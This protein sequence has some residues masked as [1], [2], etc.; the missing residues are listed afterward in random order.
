MARLR[1]STSAPVGTPMTEI[2]SMVALGSIFVLLR[3][4]VYQTHPPGV[5]GVH[6]DN[7]GPGPSGD[8]KTFYHD[9][10]VR[11]DYP[12]GCPNPKKEL[13]AFADDA[14]TPVDATYDFKLLEAGANG[15]LGDITVDAADPNATTRI[16]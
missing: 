13:G 6:V 12:T 10:T 2:K 11:C 16:N 5:D 9:D 3:P 7:T 14:D 4:T 1:N 15:P 8:Y